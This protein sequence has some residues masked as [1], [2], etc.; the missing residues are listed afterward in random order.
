MP[1][2]TMLR[3][4]ELVAQTRRAPGVEPARLDAKGVFEWRDLVA[5]RDDSD[6]VAW[7][8]ERGCEVVRGEG[9]VVSPGLVRVGERE[10]PY[11]RLVIASGSSAAIP[12]IPGLAETG[13]WTNV[14]ATETFEVPGSAARARRRPGRLRARAVLRPGRLARDARRGGRAASAGRG[15]RSRRARRGGPAGRRGRDPHRREGGVLRGQDRGARRR[16]SHRLRPRARRHRPAAEPG[17]PRRARARRRA[18]EASRS[19]SG[20]GPP[21]TSG[22]SAT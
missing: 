8:A 11:D 17:R 18:K 22:R 20:C 21:R 12:P 15:R 16:R 5:D 1:T 7:L 3:G 6:Q 10:L 19:T 13:Y 2:K 9:T 14:E 4:P